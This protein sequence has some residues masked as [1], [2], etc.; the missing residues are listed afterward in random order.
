M[1]KN[2]DL[3]AYDVKELNVAE[4]QQIEGGWALFGRNDLGIPLALAYAFK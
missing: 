4:M 1:K 2:L 3:N